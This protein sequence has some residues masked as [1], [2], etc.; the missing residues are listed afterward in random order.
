MAHGEHKEYSRSVLDI[1]T[2]LSAPLVKL[3]KKH[4]FTIASPAQN[5]LL[6]V[7]SPAAAAAARAGAAAAAAAAAAAM[8]MAARLVPPA[9]VEG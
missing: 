4:I 2:H 1:R 6:L 7:L 9:A 3:H 5:L 8:M